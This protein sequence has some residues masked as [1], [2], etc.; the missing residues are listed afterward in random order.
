MTTYS[1]ILDTQVDP[2]APITSLLGYQW[3][4]NPIAI[5]EGASGA[6]VVAAGWHPYDLVNVGGSET[7]YIYNSAVDGTVATVESPNFADGYEYAFVFR[8]VDHSGVLAVDLE[9]S[10][11]R[12]TDAAYFTNLDIATGVANG[13]NS[14][15]VIRVPFPRIAK[16]IHPVV[17]DVN[18]GQ[19]GSDYSVNNVVFQDSTVQKITK[20]RF[21]WSAN[22]FEAGTITMIRRRE[23]LTG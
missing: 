16:E 21:A 13:S 12:E 23:Y 20:V 7:G 2:D 9:M 5:A 18:F 14:I 1:S 10:L 4:D 17:W 11:Y 8:G 19:S 15:G 6:P 3:R 22:S